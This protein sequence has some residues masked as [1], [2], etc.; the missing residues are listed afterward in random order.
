MKDKLDRF[1]TNTDVSNSCVLLLKEILPKRMT[2]ELIIEPS[3]GSGFFVNALYSN[4]FS[5]IIAF[6]ISPKLSTVTEK[7]F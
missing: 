1:Y 7:L 3:A 2:S 4:G 6:D 5:N